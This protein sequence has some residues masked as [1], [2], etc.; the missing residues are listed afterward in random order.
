[1]SDY[2]IEFTFRKII[3]VENVDREDVAY[4]KAIE[5][6]SDLLG[7]PEIDLLQEMKITCATRCDKKATAK[8]VTSS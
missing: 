8:A 4:Q 3:K 6:L 5:K 2:E 1:M 7:D